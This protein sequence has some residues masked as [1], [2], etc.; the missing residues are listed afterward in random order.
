MILHSSSAPDKTCCPDFFHESA[1]LAPDFSL[2]DPGYFRQ[3][4]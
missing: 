1:R 3:N 4:H 2:P